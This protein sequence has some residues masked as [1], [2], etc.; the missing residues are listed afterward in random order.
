MGIAKEHGH[1]F[2]ADKISKLGALKKLSR[3][4]SEDELDGLAGGMWSVPPAC[5]P[6]CNLGS[7][8]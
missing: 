6:N 3:T 4:I 2:T 7:W 1:E 5:N 8:A